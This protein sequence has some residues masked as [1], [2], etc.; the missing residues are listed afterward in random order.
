MVDTPDAEVVRLVIPSRLELLSIIDKVVDGVAEQMGFEED[1]KDAVAIS[2]IEAGTN[3]IQ[4]GH[5]H[6]S[7]RMVEI[8]FRLLP[9][10]LVIEVMDNGRGF[11]LDVLEDATAPENLLKERGRGIFIMRSMMDDVHFEF[12]DSGTRCR[13]VKRRR[14]LEV[15]V[16][17]SPAPLDDTI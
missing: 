9:D 3:A 5:G 1:D 7:E 4:H 17:G 12:T 16:T 14:P 11:N 8:I 10:E 2:V 6:E 13:L 15:D